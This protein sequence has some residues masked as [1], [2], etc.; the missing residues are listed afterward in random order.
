MD[1]RRLHVAVLA[2]VFACAVA[3]SVVPAAAVEGSPSAVAVNDCWNTDNGLPILS[4]VRLAATEVD[5]RFGP[6]DVLVSVRVADTGGPG[7]STGVKS[8][9]VAVGAPPIPKFGGDGVTVQMVPAGGDWWTGTIHIPT[10]GIRVFTW[11]VFQVVAVDGAGNRLAKGID[12]LQADGLAPALT[13]I[14]PVDGLAPG[15]ADLRLSRRKLD[16]RRSAGSVRFRV[17]AV[18]SGGSGVASVWVGATPLHLV[19]GTRNNGWWQGREVLHPWSPNGK[20]RLSVRVT[21]RSGLLRPAWWGPLRDHGLPWYYRVRSRPDTAPPVLGDARFSDASLDVRDADGTV[22]VSLRVTDEQSGLV[23]VNVL[24]PGEPGQGDAAQAMRRVAGTRRDG[25]WQTRIRFP[26]CTSMPGR[27]VVRVE[28]TDRAGWATEFSPVGGVNVRAADHQ[29]AALQVLQEFRAGAGLAVGFEEPVA[30]LTPASLVLQRMPAGA[31]PG[32]TWQPVPGTWT[33][34]DQAGL[35]VDCEAGPVSR[36]AL[37]TAE[38]AAPSTSYAVIA[39]PEH[40]LALTDLA[41]NPVPPRF[42]P[43]WSTGP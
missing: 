31:P 37:V 36:A 38:V 18:D 23:S 14:A 20:H 32:T 17:R 19:S 13:L 24:V 3:A 8:V 1:A 7:P 5:T 21:D 40:V 28:A 42:G 29:P 6:R 30:G 25:T 27:F 2:P 12:D 9:R 34:A 22:V 16:V 39:N 35:A 15:V 41:G 43:S 4:E 10:W 11:K 26:R 33:C